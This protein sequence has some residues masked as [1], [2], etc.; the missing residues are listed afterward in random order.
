MTRT[1]DYDRLAASVPVNRQ[2]AVMRDGGGVSPRMPEFADHWDAPPKQER[3]PAPDT[4]RLEGR[5]FGDGMRVVRYHGCRADS[6][7][8][9]VRCACGAYELRR[10]RAVLTAP[11]DHVCQACTWTRN[12]RR[13]ATPPAVAPKAESLRIKLTI[14]ELRYIRGILSGQTVRPADSAA[15]SVGAKIDQRLSGIEREA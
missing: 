6:G 15:I 8:W 3:A 11:V 4:P 1:V 2:A 7:R 13:R 12:L 9:L 10:T 14:A 5:A